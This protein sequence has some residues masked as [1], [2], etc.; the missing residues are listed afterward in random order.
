DMGFDMQSVVYAFVKDDAGYRAMRNEMAAHSE[1]VSMAGSYNSVTRSW[2]TDPIKYESTEL[3]VDVLDIGS[4]YLD[5]IGATIVEG[6]DFIDKSQTDVERSAIVNQELVRLLGWEDPIGKRFLLRDTV[7]LFVVGV[8]RDIYVDG[9]L[10]EPLDPMVMRYVQEP[11]YRYFSLRTNLSDLTR[12][13]TIMDEKWKEIFPEELS[14]VT[15]MEEERSNSALVNRN[16]RTLF[17]FL[18]AVAI[19]LSAIG[20]FSLVSL[21]I[22]KRLKELGVRKVLGASVGHLTMKIS[23]EFLIILLIAGV[24]GSAAG[25]FLSNSLMS[26]IWSIYV[27]IGVS[28]LVISLLI[29]LVVSGLTIGGRVIRAASVNPADI[30]RD[31]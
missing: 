8:V 28:V 24:L 31:E 10:W 22:N 26:S 17:L 5:V 21:N 13:K 27:P 6:R 30:L 12:V 14:T 4:G 7:E 11:S 23:R 19:I 18:G 25:Y 1:V 20:L 29:M 15:F 2:Y 9:A 16:I 3:D